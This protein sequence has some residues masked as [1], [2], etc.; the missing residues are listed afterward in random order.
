MTSAINLL[1]T[2]SVA[3]VLFFSDLGLQN[4]QK[5]VCPA[6]I[7]S[8]SLTVSQVHISETQ[9]SVSNCGNPCQLSLCHTRLNL[10]HFQP[11]I[12]SAMV[13]GSR[14]PSVSAVSWLMCHGLW[15]KTKSSRS[16]CCFIFFCLDSGEGYI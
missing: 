3:F 16:C 11:P 6:K 9:P 1:H 8:A 14:P 13:Y 7:C 15:R 4:L 12:M 5:C 10:I 2:F